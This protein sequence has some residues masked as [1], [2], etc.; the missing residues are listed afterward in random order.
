MKDLSSVYWDKSESFRSKATLACVHFV[1]ILVVLWLL[2]AGGIERVESFFGGENHLVFVARRAALATA[3]CLYFARTL[4]TL[5]VFLRRRMP[6]SEVGVIA[7]WIAMIDL[8]LAYFGG[9][10][11]DPFGASGWIG[12]AL[13]VFGS[14]LNSG[15]EWQR[16]LWKMRSENEGH[17]MTSGFFRYSRHINYFGDEVLFFGWVLM[18]GRPALMVIPMLML[19]G[20]VFANVPAQDRYL[21]ERYG[22]EYR[23]YA[24]RTSRL[25]PYIY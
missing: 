5:F 21:A 22:E 24:K 4:L 11:D 12:A 13:I 18:T 10:N 8:V 15:S 19:C 3:A 25:I 9:R 23:A 6:W 16:H 14:V 7:V 1:I 20:F 2:F 17:L